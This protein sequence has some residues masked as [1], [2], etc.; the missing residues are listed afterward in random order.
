[1]GL[2]GTRIAPAFQAPS[3]QIRNW[4]QL[5][6]S[7][8]TRSP[9]ATPSPARAAAN[10][11]LRASSSPWVTVRPL[12]SRA[13]GARPLGGGV[14][15]VVEQGPLRVRRQRRRDALVVVLQPLHAAEPI[16]RSGG[17]GLRR[18]AGGQVEAAVGQGLG[19]QL[20]HGPGVERP[21]EQVAL[22]VWRPRAARWD[23]WS[24]CSMPSATVW[25]WRVWLSLTIAWARAVSSRPRPIPSTNALSILSMSIGKRRR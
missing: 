21:G 5:G 24:G 20:G 19:Q 8:A 9:L 17:D 15:H 13:R 12:N 1:M 11:S 16:N 23:A 25:S 10:A 22:A 7:R 2:S 4:G 14:G 6:S 3:S 18:L